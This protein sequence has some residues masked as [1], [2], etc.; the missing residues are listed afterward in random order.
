MQHVLLPSEA[1]RNLTSVFIVG[2][3]LMEVKRSFFCKKKNSAAC[4]DT[5]PCNCWKIEYIFLIVVVKPWIPSKN[6]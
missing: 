4:S 5:L 3:W 1:F 2:G 6:S